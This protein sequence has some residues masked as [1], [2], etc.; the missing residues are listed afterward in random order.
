M[1]RDIGIE[2]DAPDRKRYVV[3]I[4]QKQCQALRD[5]IAIAKQKSA[6]SAG[7]AWETS[8][9]GEV[10]MLE[11]QVRPSPPSWALSSQTLPCYNPN[12]HTS[13]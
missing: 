7:S 9:R 8:I 6:G 13:F 1:A 3:A 12:S 5:A 2:M 10:V 4:E 11:T